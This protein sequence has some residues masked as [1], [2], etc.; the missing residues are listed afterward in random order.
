MNR[1]I[2][3]RA[4][5]RRENRHLKQIQ[6]IYKILAENEK[7]LDFDCLMDT[8]STLDKYISLKKKLEK[9]PDEK[10]VRECKECCVSYP[11]SIP[12][13][14]ILYC[15]DHFVPEDCQTKYKRNWTWKYKIGN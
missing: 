7:Y 11:D 13:Y 14:E 4:K 12:G 9:H 10:I 5:L 8:I 3:E 1:T 15:K 2:K 6:R